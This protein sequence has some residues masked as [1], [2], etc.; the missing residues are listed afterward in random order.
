MNNYTTALY[1]L[2]ALISL[3]CQQPDTETPTPPKPAPTLEPLPAECEACLQ[4]QF[5]SDSSLGAYIDH[6]NNR[7]PQAPSTSG[8]GE[9]GCIYEYPRSEQAVVKNIVARL[10]HELS[11]PQKTFVR[12][13]IAHDLSALTGYVPIV[14]D[15]GKAFFVLDNDSIT[16]AVNAAWQQWYQ[17]HKEQ[18]PYDWA[19]HALH[20]T[21]HY[22]VHRAISNLRHFEDDRAIPHLLTHIDTVCFK[23]AKTQLEH[24]LKH[25]NWAILDI[26]ITA[27]SP[28]AIPYIVKYRLSDPMKAYQKD[29]YD[30]LLHI[31]GKTMGFN[32]QGSWRSR[33][34]AIKRWWAYCAQEGL[35][36]E[37]GSRAESLRQ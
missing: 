36:I 18:S 29:G 31:T 17:I 32:L 14:P 34:A 23:H 20:A 22:S 21:S 35:S 30:D 11:Q 5:A 8:Y 2:L 9:I 3:G 7:P 16:T 33:R 6:I 37:Q 13:A 27:K 1:A 26:L 25:R 15:S 12:T 28:Q 10:I 19:I 4:E 24:A